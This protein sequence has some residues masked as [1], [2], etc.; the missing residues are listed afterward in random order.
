MDLVRQS[1]DDPR[2][3]LV[4]HEENLGTMVSRMDGLAQASGDWILFL[5]GDDRFASQSCSV[6]ATVIE[7]IDEDVEILGFGVENCY[8]I[9]VGDEIKETFER[10]TAHPV[11]GRLSANQLL[12]ELYLY[13]NKGWSIWS[14]CYSTT[15]ARRAASLA[16]RDKMVL[17]EDFYLSFLFCSLAKGYLGVDV[18]LYQYS[19]GT[20]LTTSSGTSFSSFESV[21]LSKTAIERTREYARVAG[22]Y[23]RYRNVMDVV[24]RES[25]IGACWWLERLDKAEK[26]VALKMILKCFGANK[27]LSA[28]EASEI[29]SERIAKF[30]SQLKAM[31][32]ISEV[33]G[34]EMPLYR[35]N[36]NKFKMWFSKCL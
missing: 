35:K 4:Q 11:L 7:Q 8:T 30:P 19:I 23:D 20:G 5:D 33:F 28:M 31:D 22:M 14:R 24:E 25:I 18:A 12:D 27:V 9:Q 1:F 6:L 15:L 36:I 10:L 2:L 16:V 32:K 26:P 3:K 13:R 17:L 29:Y 34:I 21:L